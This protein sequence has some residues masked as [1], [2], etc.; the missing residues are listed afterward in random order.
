MLK[1][2]LFSSLG[3]LNSS[4][5][6]PSQS[7]GSWSEAEVIGRSGVSAQAESLSPGDW[8][9]PSP[10]PQ[11][12]GL[13]EPPRLCVQNTH[14]MLCVKGGGG[15]PWLTKRDSEPRSC[16]GNCSRW[17]QPASKEGS[18]VSFLQ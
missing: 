6:H 11:T 8:P 4:L 7:S 3:K 5:G 16:L 10:C 9:G 18:C 14:A 13:T 12:A 17:G 2:L 1:H 15:V